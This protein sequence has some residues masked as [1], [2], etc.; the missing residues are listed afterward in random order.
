MR[1]NLKP[2][3]AKK[4]A[5]LLTS[6]EFTQMRGSLGKFEDDKLCK[7]CFLGALCELYRRETG[8]GSWR[9]SASSIA[10]FYLNGYGFTADTPAEVDEWAVVGNVDSDTYDFLLDCECPAV[11]VETGIIQSLPNLNDGSSRLSFETLA[12]V[13]T[14]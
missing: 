14:S 5:A 9:G 12:D 11:E 7:L 3:V 8:N 13:L 2:E 6:G 4:L 10:E 1:H